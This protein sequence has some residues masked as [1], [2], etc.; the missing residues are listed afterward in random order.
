TPFLDITPSVLSGGER[1]LLGLAFHPLYRANGKF[2]VYY[3]RQT[4]GTIVV[5]EFMRSAANADL[6]DAASE[7]QVLTV[8]HPLSNHNA[9]HMAFGPDGFLY[10]AIGDGGGGGDPNNNAQ[11]LGVRLGKLLRIDVNSAPGFA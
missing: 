7:R 10:I 11:N 5:S 3:T 9:G 4:D 6:A 1:G 8:T 2:Y